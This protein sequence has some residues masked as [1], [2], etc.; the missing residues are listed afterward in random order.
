MNVDNADK[1]LTKVKQTMSSTARSKATRLK[2]IL[3]LPSRYNLS[4][5]ETGRGEMLT[6]SF[7]PLRL[8][9]S[10]HLVETQGVTFRCGC[11][12]APCGGGPAGNA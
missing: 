7:F 2:Q 9:V 5:L 11:T 8:T 1:R 4:T 3:T 6:C 10:R 12:E